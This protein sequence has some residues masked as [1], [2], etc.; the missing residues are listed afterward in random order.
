M[1]AFHLS[2]FRNIHTCTCTFEHLQKLLEARYK[3]RYCNCMSAWQMR[4]AQHQLLMHLTMPCDTA[5]AHV[6]THS[7]HMNFFDI[8]KY[9]S[10]RVSNVIFYCVCT[11]MTFRGVYSIFMQF[12]SKYATYVL[13][14]SV[15]REWNFKHCLSSDHWELLCKL[16]GQTPG[17]FQECAAYIIHHR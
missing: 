9:D 2:I 6:H 3:L 15:D 17:E 12:L 11:P 10:I 5:Q 8:K 14:Q 13:D 7:Q 16:P 1:E 4:S